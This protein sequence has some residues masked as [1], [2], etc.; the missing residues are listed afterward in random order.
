MT[1]GW[2]SHSGGRGRAMRAAWREYAAMMAG[3][4]GRGGPEDEDVGGAGRWGGRGGRGWGGGGGR[5]LGHGDL[6]ILVLA[7]VGEKPRHGY[8]LIRAISDRFA[9]AYTPSP[10]AVYPLLTMLEEEDLISAT[11]DGAKKLYTLTSEGEAWL[12]DN[13]T[14]VQG[15]LT[16]IDLAA[17]AYSSQSAP[18]SVWEAWKTLKQ[19]MNMPRAPWTEAEAD[20]IRAILEK[21]ARDIVRPPENKKS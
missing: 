4:R 19:A 17:S 2:H 1:H 6:R 20:R 18:E 21:A 14:A 16:R 11:A 3:R 9:G 13:D 12:K 10:G 15:I 5:A 7:L 8:D